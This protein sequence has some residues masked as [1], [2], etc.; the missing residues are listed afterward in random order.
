MN[1]AAAK[2]KAREA[3]HVPEKT[4]ECECCGR[5]NVKESDLVKIDSG[6]LFCKD[7]LKELRG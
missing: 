1:I 5:K 6:Q 4:G 2:E 7:C 3:R